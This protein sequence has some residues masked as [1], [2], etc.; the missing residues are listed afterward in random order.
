M[1]ELCRIRP[2]KRGDVPAM[3]AVHIETWRDT[4]AD[5]LPAGY[6]VSLNAGRVAF[7]WQRALARPASEIVLVAELPEAGVIGFVSGGPNRSRP[8]G[9]AASY[10][11]EIYTLYVA[12]EHQS[13]GVGR[14]LVAAIGERLVRAGLDSVLVWVVAGNPARFFYRRLGGQPVAERRE[15]FAG[16]EIDQ[17]AFGWADMRRSIV[18]AGPPALT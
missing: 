12:T 17:I 11:G 1:T 14:R 18:P 13:V 8:V 3:V 5:L 2:A 4:Y 15:R 6:L 10:R 9:A 16:V 7:D